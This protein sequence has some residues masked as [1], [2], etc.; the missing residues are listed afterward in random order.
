MAER[1][2]L[3]WEGERDKRERKNNRVQA[4]GERYEEKID[5]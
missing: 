4:K 2:T 3:Y 1:K 5:V